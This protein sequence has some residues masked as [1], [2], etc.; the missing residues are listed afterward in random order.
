MLELK[1]WDKGDSGIREVNMTPL[2]DVSL[3]LVVI[4]LLATPLAF[5]SSIDVR[6]SREAAQKAEESRQ[7][8][9]IE[10]V[11]LSEEEVRVNRVVVSREE[12][13]NT[14]RPLIQASVD[15][16]VTVSCEDGV[17]HGAFVYTLDQ[18]KMSGAVQIAVT[19]K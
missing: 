2:I 6:N 14:L 8:E 1:K 18:A 19:G 5:E 17:S 15:R 4:L 9:R 13:Q 3:V 7:D 16:T 10:V 12:L 11:V